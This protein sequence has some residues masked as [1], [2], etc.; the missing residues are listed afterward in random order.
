MSQSIYEVLD[1][2]DIHYQE[3][4]HPPVF[5]CEDSDEHYADIPGIRAKNIFLRDRKARNHVLVVMSRH[6]KLDLKE[7]QEYMDL[8]KLGL[9]SE[10]RL[11]KYLGVKPGSV[12]PFGLINDSEKEVKVILDKAI[13][14]SEY[15]HF[16]PLVNTATLVLK[17]S[18]L[19]KFIESM[20]NQFEVVDL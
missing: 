12:T 8:R 2:L 4:K 13:I 5:T 15:C 11:E 20:G 9:A 6:K 14:E 1:S 7:L 10:E 3:H 16:H 18:D 19:L 17:S